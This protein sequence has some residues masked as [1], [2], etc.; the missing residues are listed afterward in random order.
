MGLRACVL[1]EMC[2]GKAT[3]TTG[4]EKIGCQAW[5]PKVTLKLGCTL[6]LHPKQHLRRFLPQQPWSFSWA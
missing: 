4:L 5:A 2:G 1:S 6:S 3:H